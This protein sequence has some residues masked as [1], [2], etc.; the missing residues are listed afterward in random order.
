[1]YVLKND[2]LIPMKTIFYP[3]GEQ[4]KGEYGWLSTRYSFS[5]A[6]WYDPRKMGFGALRVLNDDVIAGGQGFGT[7]GHKDME[8][9]T[10]VMHGAIRHK[11]SMGNEYVV[12][13][14]D[15]QVMSAGTGV[16]H[17]E[18]NAS[19]DDSLKLFQLWIVPKERSIVP[20]YD[21]KN[22]NFK[23][24]KNGTVELVGVSSLKINQEAYISY[25]ALDANTTLTY[26]MHNP[27][28]GV[29][30]FVVEGSVKIGEQVLEKRDAL[31]IWDSASIKIT[32]STNASFLLIEVPIT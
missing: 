28:F 27:A 6:D 2:T 7:H 5:F 20:R 32:G 15:V 31:G 18:H 4:G 11:D 26:D 16:Q 22:F 12:E 24:I 25:G 21:Q 14:G 19:K 9:I 3:E 1:M 8:I 17:S 23:D 10:I 30:V 13:E 29:Y